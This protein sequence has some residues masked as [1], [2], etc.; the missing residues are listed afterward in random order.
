[1]STA[2]SKSSKAILGR[3]LD[4]TDA[5]LQ[6]IMSPAHFVNVRTTHGGPAPSETSRAIAESKRLLQADRG[7]WKTR[8][9]HLARAE[10]LLTARA[11]AL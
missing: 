7:K 5:D 3:A 6:R 4:Y 2:L 1:M 8:R 10:A 11:Q 9:D